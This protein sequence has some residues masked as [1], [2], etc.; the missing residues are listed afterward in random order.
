[1]D[2]KIIASMSFTPGKLTV[3][4]RYVIWKIRLW[5]KYAGWQNKRR[6]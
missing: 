2:D 1:M 4:Q 3:K 6:K 5:I